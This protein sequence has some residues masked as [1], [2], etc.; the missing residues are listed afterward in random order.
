MPL[1]EV[2]PNLPTRPVALELRK[3]REE[4]VDDI[5]GVP[6]RWPSEYTLQHRGVLAEPRA[7]TRTTT[8]LQASGIRT[9]RRERVAGRMNRT[10]HVDAVRSARA[11]VKREARLAVLVPLHFE[12]VDAIRDATAKDRRPGL[13]PF[14][15]HE[16]AIAC[17]GEEPCFQR[18]TELGGGSH[19]VGIRSVRVRSR[20]VAHF[21]RIAA[22]RAHERPKEVGGGIEGRMARAV[23]G[24]LLLDGG[25]IHR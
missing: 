5:A 9:P 23:A 22:A 8:R 1:S 25:L 18:A 7:R 16:A 15:G 13:Q 12:D 10:V 11:E 17:V 4:L 19:I 20:I 21:R 3:E 6:K 2:R 24:E 14:V